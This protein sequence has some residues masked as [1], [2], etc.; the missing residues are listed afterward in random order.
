MS[1][2]F[3]QLIELLEVFRNRNAIRLC[4]LATWQ[5]W[6]KPSRLSFLVWL[7]MNVYKS[8]GCMVCKMVHGFWIDFTFVY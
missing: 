8:C 5:V 3:I 2:L 6:T 7:C 1:N 4:K